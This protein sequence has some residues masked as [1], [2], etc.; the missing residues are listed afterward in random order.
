MGVYLV[1]FFYLRNAKTVTPIRPKFF[2]NPPTKNL[3]SDLF[4]QLKTFKENKLGIN[5]IYFL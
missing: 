5:T 4:F 1:F 3:K 2:E